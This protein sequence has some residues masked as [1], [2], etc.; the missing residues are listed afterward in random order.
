LLKIARFLTKPG[1][2]VFLERRATLDNQQ[3]HQ[4]KQ[5]EHQPHLNRVA[6]DR[7]LA[8]HRCAST[9]QYEARADLA[10]NES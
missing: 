5:C 2:F 8:T 10:I 1:D 9:Q 6:Y 3:N 4:H 7:I